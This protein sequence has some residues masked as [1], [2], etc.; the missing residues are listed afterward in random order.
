MRVSNSNVSNTYCTDWELDNNPPTF[1]L[2][3]DGFPFSFDWYINFVKFSCFIAC[4]P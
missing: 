3:Q 2:D 1:L 4:I